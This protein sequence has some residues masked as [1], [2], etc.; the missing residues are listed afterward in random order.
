MM[1][2]SLHDIKIGVLIDRVIPGGAEKIAIKQVQTFRKL[3]YEAIY[4][5]IYSNI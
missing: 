2:E 4:V 5:H 1:S 3:G